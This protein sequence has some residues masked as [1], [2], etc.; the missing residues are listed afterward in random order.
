MITIT[1]FSRDTPKKAEQLITLRITNNDINELLEGVYRSDKFNAVFSIEDYSSI[2][3]LIKTD[4]SEDNN[5][6]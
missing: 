5:E 6:Y 4:R 2:K 3:D 1:T